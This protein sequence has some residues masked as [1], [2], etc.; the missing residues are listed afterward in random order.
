MI[1]SDR[2]FSRFESNSRIGVTTSEGGSLGN[3]STC[4]RHEYEFADNSSF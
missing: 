3:V 4:L 2:S 1:D